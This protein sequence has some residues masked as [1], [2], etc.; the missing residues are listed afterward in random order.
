MT[1]LDELREKIRDVPDFP[2]KGIVFKDI[3]PL[4][5]DGN[6]FREAV[7]MLA[8]Q[9]KS[10]RVDVVA[11]I[12]ARGFILGAAVARELGV[13]FVPIRKKGKL[14]YRTVGVEYALEYGA[15][16][17]EMHEDAI[18]S[19]EHVLIVDDLLATGGTAKAAAELVQRQDGIVVGVAFL[20]E[21]AFLNG[22]K[23]LEGLPVYS[24][25]KYSSD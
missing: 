17:I 24:V 23:Q 2:R 22:R 20:I 21:L 8:E 19:G 4:L 14:P 25:I 12:E 13:G 1:S 3:T 5:R 15:D 11:G 9:Y 18:K 6:C 16:R 10:R 7:S